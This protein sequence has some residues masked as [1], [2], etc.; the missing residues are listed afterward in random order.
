[1]TELALTLGFMHLA[2]CTWQIRALPADSEGMRLFK[3]QYVA[4][5]GTLGTFANAV[6]PPP[7]GQIAA[8]V[9]E[10]AGAIVS[11]LQ[12]TCSPCDE[13]KMLESKA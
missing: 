12:R 10:V 11:A 4:L 13:L 3:E 6:V 2:S 7:G 5:Q 9:V 1:M 8:V